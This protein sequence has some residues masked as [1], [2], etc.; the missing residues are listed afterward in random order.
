MISHKLKSILEKDATTSA[1]KRM[2]INS[3]IVRCFRL[4]RTC[5][6]NPQDDTILLQPD[7]KGKHKALKEI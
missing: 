5:S 4:F 2:S 6:E 3:L 7:L 1:K